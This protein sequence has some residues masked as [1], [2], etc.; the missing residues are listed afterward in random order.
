MPELP[1]VEI[2]VRRL[3]T[4]AIGLTIASA[5][6]SLLKWAK[7]LPNNFINNLVGV[8]IVKIQRLAKFILIFLDNEQ[9]LVVHLGMSGNL[10]WNQIP[11]PLAKHDYFTIN[12]LE[13]GQIRF[14]DPRQF[15]K[16]LLIP[17]T[18]WQNSPIFSNFAPDPFDP[19]F[20]AQSWLTKCGKKKVAI[21]TV[22][23][24][25]GLMSGVGNIYA[26]E[27]LFLA[28]ISPLTPANQLTTKQWLELLAAIKEIL[29]QA[30][31]LGGSSFKDY[32][33]PD[34]STG[35]FQ[36]VNAVYAH[37]NKPCSKPMCSSLILRVVQAGRAT[38]YC[39]SCQK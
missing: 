10:F 5:N 26:S 27:S 36:E 39:P 37:A 6:L 18:N 9:I 1:E 13:G 16:L 31:N 8:K 32:R 30:I 29:L 20:N 11:Q 35:H 28:N 22:L 24:D 17:N 12:F 4:Q 23:L 19:K 25:Q 7:G 15:G 2:V 3:A 21:K 14:N 38:F 33:N 34:G